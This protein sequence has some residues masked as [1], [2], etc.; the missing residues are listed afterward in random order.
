M[1]DDPR[2]FWNMPFPGYYPAKP[3][4]TGYA[5][6]DGYNYNPAGSI[7]GPVPKIYTVPGQWIGE[8]LAM[9]GRFQPGAGNVVRT[10]TWSSPVFD[11]RPELRASGGEAPR[12]AVPVWR[13]LFGVGGKLWVQTAGWRS[14]NL[15]KTGLRVTS[16]EYAHIT[17][18]RNLVQIDAFEDV[19]A[20]MSGPE[21]SHILVFVPPGDGYPVRFWR[22]ELVFDYLIDNGG[23]PNT[24][25]QG[26]YY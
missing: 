13:Q 8:P 12:N 4:Q 3:D 5:H 6:S 1:R 21:P 24:S 20:E 14:G 7:P 26:A 10:M 16:R 17:D 11:L 22:L 23:A 19:T 25:I 15:T 18:Q 2:H 9:Q